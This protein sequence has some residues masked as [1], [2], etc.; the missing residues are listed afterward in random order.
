MSTGAISLATAIAVDTRARQELRDGIANAYAEAA[1][2]YDIPDGAERWFEA[3]VDAVA[4]RLAPSIAA[5]LD[6]ELE[7]ELAKRRA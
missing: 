4:M 5:I 7:A 3:A 2:V 6:A 1:A